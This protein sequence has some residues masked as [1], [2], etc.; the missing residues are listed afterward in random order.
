MRGLLQRV[1]FSFVS[2]QDYYVYYKKKMVTVN[3]NYWKKLEYTKY[4][5]AVKKFINKLQSNKYLHFCLFRN[6]RCVF[7]ESVSLIKNDKI[8]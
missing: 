7:V 1:A 2:I 5:G 3:G 8:I 6:K 4:E